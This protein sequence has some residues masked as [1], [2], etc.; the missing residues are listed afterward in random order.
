MRRAWTRACYMV[1]AMVALAWFGCGAAVSWN[2]LVYVPYTVCRIDVYVR[3]IRDAVAP[4][5]DP[6][7]ID[8]PE[9]I[10][11]VKSVIGHEIGHGVSLDHCTFANC[12]MQ[13]APP[14]GVTGYTDGSHNHNLEYDLTY[15]LAVPY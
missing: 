9:D 14:P 10:D 12:G 7:V 5:F 3:R 15:A 11:F 4:T 2:P 6:D 13:A 8:N 1:G